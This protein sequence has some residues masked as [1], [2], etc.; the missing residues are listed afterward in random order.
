MNKLKEVKLAIKNTPPQRLAKIEYQ[1]HFM[2]MIGVSVVCGILI[3]KGFWW[4]IFAFIFSLGVTFSQWV[5]SM[6][7][8]KGIMEIVQPEPYDYKKDKSPSRRRD[9]I[10]KQTFGRYTWI[11]VAAFTIYTVIY[12]VPRD[13]WY[14]KLVFSL[15]IIFFYIF[16]YFFVTYWLAKKVGGYKDVD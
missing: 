3:W 9:Y 15:S 5:S 6:Q 7:K 1:S 13:I 12:Y 4:I 10:I 14:M 2:H 8:Y 16:W 11:V